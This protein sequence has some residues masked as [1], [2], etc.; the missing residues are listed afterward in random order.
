MDGSRNPMIHKDIFGEKTVKDIGKDNDKRVS[1]LNDLK[2]RTSK[3][4]DN[5]SDAII[6]ACYL[7][8]ETDTMNCWKKIE[9]KTSKR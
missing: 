9:K 8:N 2:K 1:L 4:T 7:G 5:Y 3:C 6:T